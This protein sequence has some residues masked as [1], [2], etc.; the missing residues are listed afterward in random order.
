MCTKLH[1]INGEALQDVENKKELEFPTTTNFKA[2]FTCSKLAKCARAVLHIIRQIRGNLLQTFRI[3]KELDICLQFSEFFEFAVTSNLRGQWVHP[4]NLRIQ[5]ARLDVL[6]NGKMAR[7][8]ITIRM[9]LARSAFLAFKHN[10]FYCFYNSISSGLPRRLSLLLGQYPSIQIRKP[11]DGLEKTVKE[12]Q[13]AVSESST[14]VQWCFVGLGLAH[15]SI[16]FWTRTWVMQLTLLV[17]FL[18]LLVYLAS[19]V[20]L[21]EKLSYLWE[22]VYSLPG[23][24]QTSPPGNLKDILVPP[25]LKAAWQQALRYERRLYDFADGYLDYLV[26]FT[27][28]GLM[29]LVAVLLTYFL[30]LQV[31]NA[32]VAVSNWYPTLTVALLPSGHTPGYRHDWRAKPVEFLRNPRSN[33]PEWRT[34]LV[35]RELVSYKVDLSALSET[36][37]SEQGQLEEVDAGYTFL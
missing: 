30:L 8:A 9:D 18:C 33:R 14:V 5:Q 22:V 28:I 31:V 17:G 25:V 11:A 35:A 7:K 21:L 16:A 27:L 10:T 20:H 19:R 23:K 2:S 26:S 1:F 12:D 36:R 13:K 3:V 37:F 6:R 34:A 32:L 15:F 24:S 4:F 29:V